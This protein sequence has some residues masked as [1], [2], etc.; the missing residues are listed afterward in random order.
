MVWFLRMVKFAG[1]FTC[2]F[3]VSLSRNR[4]LKVL[5]SVPIWEDLWVRYMNVSYRDFCIFYFGAYCYYFFVVVCGEFG[6][7]NDWVLILLCPGQKRNLA[8]FVFFLVDPNNW[9]SISLD[10][11]FFF[12][13]LDAK[14]FG[15]RTQDL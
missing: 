12:M 10:Y 1:N 13:V 2:I 6:V 4:A 8:F 9:G 14:I 11:N 5:K 7:M 3:F 15:G